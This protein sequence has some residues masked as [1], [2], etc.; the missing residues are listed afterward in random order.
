MTTTRFLA[1][2]NVEK[3]VIEFLVN[4][5]FDVKWLPDFDAAL[6][7][8]ALLGIGR[9][10]K[11]ILITND[12][13]FGELVFLQKKLTTGIVLIRVKGH[14]VDRKVALLETLLENHGD[15][16]LNHFIILTNEKIRIIPMEESH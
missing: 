2:V 16:L 5:G 15:K 14:I 11:R 6:S 4:R 8:E 9:N 10:E 3:K 1:D 13:D 7:D 12:K